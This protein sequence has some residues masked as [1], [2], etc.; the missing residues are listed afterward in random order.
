MDQGYT[1]NTPIE[2]SQYYPI[3]KEADPPWPR[4]SPGRT[5]IIEGY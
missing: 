4:K 5:Y 3:I 1:M 2:Q